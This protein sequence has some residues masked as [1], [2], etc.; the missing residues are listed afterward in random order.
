MIL[1]I[2]GTATQAA[3]GLQSHRADRII[4]PRDEIE[5]SVDIQDDDRDNR[6]LFDNGKRLNTVKSIS[7]DGVD[8]LRLLLA[9][10]EE[11][12]FASRRSLR[13]SS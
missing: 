5:V 8:Q 12:L 7:H 11:V 9:T 3:S 10:I 1:V 13:N 4:L 6:D 2:T